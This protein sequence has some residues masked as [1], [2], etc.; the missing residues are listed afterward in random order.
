METELSLATANRSRDPAVDRLSIPKA[1]TEVHGLDEVL[2]GGLPR[3]RA[4]L[5]G[6]GPGTGKT[7]LGLE[8]LYRG[9]LAGEPGILLTF[10][11]QA[12]A[13]R[14]NAQTL[15]WNL[16]AL[17]RAGSLAIIDAG[18]PTD[19][20]ATGE[21]DIGGVL[22]ILGGRI[23]E[24]G[25]R[26]VVIDAA[27]LLLRLFRDP[28]R[29]EDQL[30]ALHQWLI[31]QQQT[32][33]IT[34]K[35]SNEPTEPM[36]RLEYLTDCVLRLDH[37]VLGQVSTRRLRVLKYRGSSFLSNEYPYVIGAQGLVLM[38]ISSL[39]LTA[40]AYGARF[41][42]EVYGLD[43]LVGGGFFHGSS[44][45]IG[46]ASGTGKTIL[47]CSIATAAGARGERVLYISFEE[48]AESLVASVRSA[49]LDLDSA[50]QS[51]ILRF[52]T[53][54]PEAMGV[55]EHLWRIFQV[56][57]SF[58][59]QHVIFDAISACQRMGSEEA[60][61]DF[62]VRLLT[63][64]K[65]RGTTCI[66]LNQTNPRDSIDQLSGVGISSLI[67]ALLVLRQ[68]WPQD[69][70]HRRSALVVKVRGSRHAHH[71]TSFQIT[72]DGIEFED[73]RVQAPAREA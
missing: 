40:R 56:V 41:P 27:D 34:V 29:E 39:A 17:E 4:T 69:D 33:I 61:F 13:I 35:T 3:G 18:V 30:I 11:E 50:L 24:L 52:L 54:I 19:V 45:L 16:D 2:L 25:A 28:R 62:V 31:E 42:T 51:G 73:A 67:D 65:A 37:R 70:A 26:R 48:S 23:R 43:A 10:E 12:E 44:V 6:G 22:A 47:A 55:E 59:P 60:A 49:G 8:F 72:D 9:A 71:P 68:D 20:V 7:I 66:Y 46:G 32:V 1:A 15:G 36:H 57:E 38:P 58:D 5:V 14:R 63:H 53:S 21:F 64:C